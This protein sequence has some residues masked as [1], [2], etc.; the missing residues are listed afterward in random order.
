[1]E[2]ITKQEVIEFITETGANLFGKRVK[3][4]AEKMADEI[5]EEHNE[6]GD[7]NLQK[8]IAYVVQDKF[9]VEEMPTD[10]PPKLTCV[11][12]L[13]LMVGCDIKHELTASLKVEGML[14]YLQEQGVIETYNADRL[15]Y[16][17]GNDEP[18]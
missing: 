14:N 1:M 18:Y 11:E 6:A 16:V 9:K 3:D 15:D 5:V 7:G 13:C 12:D 2:N 17:F 10:K 8:A 4:V